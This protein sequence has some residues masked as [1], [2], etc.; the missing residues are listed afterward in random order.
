MVLFAKATFST[1]PDEGNGGSGTQPVANIWRG[2][3]FLPSSCGC[4][5]ASEVETRFLQLGSRTLPLKK[6]VFTVY[7]KRAFN[8]V[9]IV[10]LLLSSSV[11]FL[12]I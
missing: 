6:I 11:P 10:V 3:K 2:R 7:W 1:V 12:T 4:L 8:D 5:V 9:T